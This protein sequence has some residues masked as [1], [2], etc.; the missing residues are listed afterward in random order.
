MKKSFNHGL[1]NLKSH[2]E[3]DEAYAKKE[4][5]TLKRNFNLLIH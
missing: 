2:C 1:T 4:G 5:S 3:S